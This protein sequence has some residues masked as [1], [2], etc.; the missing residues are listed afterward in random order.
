MKLGR[1][2]RA[3]HFDQNPNAAGAAEIPQ[4]SKLAGKRA[5]YEPH[6]AP[7]CHVGAEAD[8]AFRRARIK[9]SFDDAASDRCR[10]ALM[11]DE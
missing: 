6:A 9:K 4:D 1:N 2:V 11:H 8:L 3:H 7:R 5:G 10:K